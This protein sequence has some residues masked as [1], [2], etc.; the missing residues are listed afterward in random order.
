MKL[1]SSKKTITSTFPIHSHYINYSILYKEKPLRP[2]S[3]IP[4]N[5]IKTHII[6]II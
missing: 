2:I 1:S 4:D 3:N 5:M 6:W